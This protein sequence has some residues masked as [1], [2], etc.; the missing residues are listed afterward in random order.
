MHSSLRALIRLLHLKHHKRVSEEDWD[1]IMKLEDHMNKRSP[2]ETSRGLWMAQS[3]LTF[4]K[5]PGSLSD[6]AVSSLYF[7]VKF[8]LLCNFEKLYTC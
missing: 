1:K 3:A 6:S 7:K 8:N 5:L 4:C 2:E